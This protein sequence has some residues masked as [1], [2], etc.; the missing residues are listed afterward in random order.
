MGP[1]DVLVV[2]SK[3][4]Y[5][6]LRHLWSFASDEITN[7]FSSLVSIYERHLKV[8]HDQVV[9]SLMLFEE[10]FDF[11]KGLVSIVGNINLK[12]VLIE[13]GYHMAHV[14]AIVVYNKHSRSPSC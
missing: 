10:L 9:S 5:E 1:I 4:A 14:I 3:T 12:T 6:G 2:R 13:E 11:C 7:I 8:H